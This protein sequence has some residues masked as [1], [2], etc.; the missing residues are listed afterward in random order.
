MLLLF[1]RGG[2]GVRGLNQGVFQ[3]LVGTTSTAFPNQDPNV[4]Q[5]RNL[6]RER[7]PRRKQSHKLWLNQTVAAYLFVAQDWL[8]E[9]EETRLSETATK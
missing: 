8:M 4:S 9:M 1:F 3:N 7:G 5:I 6:T 2:P